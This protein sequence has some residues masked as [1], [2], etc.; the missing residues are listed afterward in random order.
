MMIE[1]IFGDILTKSGIPTYGVPGF[2]V[3]VL[4]EQAHATIVR[5]EKIALEL[6]L[7]HSLVGTRSVVIV[8]QVGMNALVDTLA[9]ATFQ[10]VQAGV[11]IIAGDDEYLSYSQTSQDSR[12]YGP[13]TR[14]AIVELQGRHPVEALEDAFRASERFSRIAILR[15]TDGELRSPAIGEDMYQPI[16]VTPT[17]EIR[18][19]LADPDLTMYGR[20]MRVQEIT[21]KMMGYQGGLV[22]PRIDPAPHLTPAH[23]HR[24]SR[25]KSLTLCHTCPFRDL[26]DMFESAKKPVVCD[27]GCC[28]LLMNTPYTVGLVSYGMGSAI[29]T[30]H[31]T[32]IAFVG[33]YALLHSGLPALIEIYERKI[34]VI[35][36]IIQNYKLGMTGGQPM[37]DIMPY[38]GFANPTVYNCSDNTALQAIKSAIVTP[39][40]ERKEPRTFVVQGS[41]QEVISHEYVEC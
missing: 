16:S 33:D 6:A 14:S 11:I 29:A 26:F 15:V 13:V 22:Y 21:D 41:C 27:A 1:N 10:G 34:P 19:G 12:C 3:S 37:P 35:T 36:V 17:E 5:N 40:R 31:T 32:G 9:N 25:K 23:T 38:I 39:I 7:G 20:G 28:V 30:A 2:P 18:P 4:C 24:S 8:K